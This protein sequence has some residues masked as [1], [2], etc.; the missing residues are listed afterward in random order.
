MLRKALFG[1]VLTFILSCAGSKSGVQNSKLLPISFTT[2]PCLGRCPEFNLTV[3]PS[4]KLTYD[5]IKHVK[6]TGTRKLELDKEKLRAFYDAVG[7]VNW[8]GL[9]DKYV[10]SRRDLPGTKI[11]YG[12]QKILIKGKKEAPPELQAVLAFLDEFVQQIEQE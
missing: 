6:V 2:M 5:G 7:G 10:S 3:Y 8:E 12:A 9:S 1:I 4:G 11:S